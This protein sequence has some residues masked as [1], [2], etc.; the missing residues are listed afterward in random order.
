LF[1]DDVKPLR[2]KESLWGSNMDVTNEM[3][4]LQVS[5]LFYTTLSTRKE[6][7]AFTS[8]V[9]FIYFCGNLSFPLIGSCI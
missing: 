3:L 2:G 4:I 6:F 1:L 9:T 8:W 7:W 5:F